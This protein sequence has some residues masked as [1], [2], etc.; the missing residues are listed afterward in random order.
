[1]GFQDEREI[2]VAGNKDF[3]QFRLQNYP[4]RPDPDNQPHFKYYNMRIRIPEDFFLIFETLPSLKADPRATES[5]SA[6]LF[7]KHMFT[8]PDPGSAPL[9]L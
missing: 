1:M 3:M 4:L 7:Y 6:R 2:E 9:V 5:G 8:R